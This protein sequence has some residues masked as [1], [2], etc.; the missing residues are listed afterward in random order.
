MNLI[1]STCWSPEGHVTNRRQPFPWD[2]FLLARDAEGTQKFEETTPTHTLRHQFKA[3]GCTF[4]ILKFEF[5]LNCSSLDK[6]TR[7]D[8]PQLYM[9]RSGAIILHDMD[10]GEKYLATSFVIA[11][12]H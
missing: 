8:L 4:S 7:N 2:Y 10:R 5:G 9:D 11:V 12:C 3:S 6:F 1:G